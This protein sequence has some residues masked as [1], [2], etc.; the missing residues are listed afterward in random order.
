MSRIAAEREAKEQ[1]RFLAEASRLLFHSLDYEATLA[2]AARLALP[3][4]GAWCIVDLYEPGHRM[5]RVAVVHPDPEM[6]PLVDRLESGWPPERGDPFGIPRVI[7]TGQSEVIG[8]VTDEM[9]QRAAH[10]GENLD[11]LRQLGIGSLMTVP[12]EARER[13]LGAITYIAPR[14][15][16]PYTDADLG[17]AEDLG[18]RCA[19]AIENAQLYRT[20]HRR[21]DRLERLHTMSAALLKSLTAEEV[22]DTVVSAG[23]EAFGA[24]AGFAGLLSPDGDSLE[25]V[26]KTGYPEVFQA[27]WRRVPVE[28]RVPITEVIR[29]GEPL[30]FSS[31]AERDACFPD[32]PGPTGFEAIASAPFVVEGRTLGSWTLHFHHAREFSEDERAFFAT[33]TGQ[34]AQALERVRLYEAE[35]RARAE[36]EEANRAKALFLTTMSHELR[37]PLNAIAGYADLMEMGLRGPLT[38]EGRTD[39]GRIRA[40]QRHLLGLVNSVLDYARIESGRMEFDVQD[41]SLGEALEHTDALVLPLALQKGIVYANDSRD[42]SC[43]V[44]ADADKLQQIL[45]NLI[46]NAIKFTPAAGRVWVE[47]ERLNGRVEVRVRDTGAGIAPEHVNVIFQPFIQVSEGLTRKEEGT[48]LGLAISRNLARGMG[49]DITVE[50]QPGEGSTFTLTLTPAEGGG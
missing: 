45:V 16:H 40:N 22:A 43:V 44:R 19:V 30:F 23:R 1:A 21:A 48:G 41:L 17:L 39:I 4:L 11:A 13:I 14:A 25:S 32:I 3:H 46:G 12:M 26:G 6:Q 33:L 35:H 34:C 42:I 47:C 49:G 8:E 37:T 27:R 9:L 31:R 7:A 50:S 28:L 5:R 15:Y 36:A 24:E 18:V 2:M 29:T 20:A 10:T 38:E